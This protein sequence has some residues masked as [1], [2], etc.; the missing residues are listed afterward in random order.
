MTVA[1]RYSLFNAND[2]TGQGYRTKH[3]ETFQEGSDF[4][5]DTYSLREAVEDFAPAEDCFWDRAC[6]DRPPLFENPAT[7]EGAK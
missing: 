2:F 6:Y 4:G 5:V 1:D 3:N 7:I